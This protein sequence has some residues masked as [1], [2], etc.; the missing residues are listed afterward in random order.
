MVTQRG[1]SSRPKRVKARLQTR[2]RLLDFSL[3]KVDL[4]QLSVATRLLLACAGPREEV[5]RLAQRRSSLVQAAKV[6]EGYPL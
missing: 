2:D 1:S 6:E 4:A 3:S 5:D